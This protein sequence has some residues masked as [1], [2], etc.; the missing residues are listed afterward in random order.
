MHSIRRFVLPFVCLTILIG[1]EVPFGGSHAGL[2]AQQISAM[3]AADEAKRGIELYDRG[4]D[5]G[6]IIMLR[7]ALNRREDMVAGWYYL[8]LAY[9]R[10]GKPKDTRKAYERATIGGENILEWMFSTFPSDKVRQQFKTQL[11]IAAESAQRYLKLSPKLSSSKVQDWVIR[12]EVLREYE[13]MAGDENQ[14]GRLNKVYPPSEVMTKARILRRTEP[15]YTEEARKNNIAGTVVIRAVFAFDGKVR[16]IRVIQ[17]LP[18][19]L[20][21]GSVQAARSIKFIPATVNGQPVSQF[22]QIEYNF[23]LY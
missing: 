16:G 23:S 11:L 12:S 21:L 20:T 4:D 17:G 7:N 9:E 5:Q 8:G 15:Q 13:G 2:Y 1:A 14:N 3:S 6:A 10:Q 18:F 19:G 22:I